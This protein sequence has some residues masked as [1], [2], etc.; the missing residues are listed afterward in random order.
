MSCFNSNP[1]AIIVSLLAT[2]VTLHAADEGWIP[3]APPA[4]VIPPSQ[5][6]GSC[7]V[8]PGYA[9]ELVASE[10]LIHDPV[11]VAF[12]PAGRLWVVEMCGFMPNPEGTGE[13]EPNGRIVILEDTKGDG[14]MDKATVFL[15]H[16]ILPRAISLVD[17]GAIVAEPPHLWLCH[18]RK[19][20]LVADEKTEIAADFGKPGNP[21]HTANGLLRGIDNWLYSA[22]H[23]LRYRQEGGTWRSEPTISRGQWGISQ[24]DTGILFYNSNSDPLRADLL[25]AEQLARNPNL[26]TP[27]ALNA[28]MDTDREAWS[29]RVNPGVNRGYKAG[30]L[31]PKNEKHGVPG[32]LKGFTAA[33]GPCVYRGDLMPELT[34][35]VFFAEP[36][37]NIVR[38]T[39]VTTDGYRT[40]GKNAYHEHEFIASTDER[41]RPVNF[42][43]GPDG[44]LYVVDMYKGIIQHRIFL[45]PYLK[46]QALSR[47]LDKPNHLGRIYRVVPTGKPVP[48]IRPALDRATTTELISHLGDAGG[49]W[50]DT[51][52]RLLVERADPAAVPAL[53][54]VVQGSANPLARLHALWTLEGFGQRDPEVLATAFADR[55]PR[56]R[57]A[58]LRLAQP[59]LLT[60][61]GTALVTPA[62]ALLQD[63]AAAVRLQAAMVLGPVADPRILGALGGLLHRDGAAPLVREAALSG[64]GGREQALLTTLLGDP[65]WATEAPGLSAVIA[66]FARAAAQAEGAAGIPRLEALAT[67]QSQTWRSAA[68][69]EGLAVAKRKPAMKAKDPGEAPL[70]AAEEARVASGKERFALLCAACHQVSGQG[71]AGI[72]PPLAGSE[73]VVGSEQRLTRIVLNGVDGPITA[74]GTTFAGEMPPMG[75]G[76]DDAAVAEILTYIRNDWGN[77]ASPVETATVTAIRAAAGTR[78]AWSVKELGKL[79]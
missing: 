8:A 38:R 73:W 48:R 76:L 24:D 40:T 39:V 32:G 13:D 28:A 71:M 50:R 51:A 53:R 49:W 41:F 21:E 10:P 14:V 27:T 25:P 42:A 56:V 74:N 46:K 45:T 47:G 3:P 30:S 18:D 75:A 78:G 15:D 37:A 31:R 58:A 79:P 72:A 65:A 34:G 9:L 35:S 33:C 54:R 6:V 5:A 20:D 2:A 77:Q 1:L 16:L 62:L 60:S 67:A 29:N 36:A 70:S 43:N 61:A 23:T 17:G 55:D 4:P 57:A 11:Q 68:L 26:G 7:T 52:Q 69:R 59:G 22:N 12:D 19:G 63:P 64:L 44:A 66:S